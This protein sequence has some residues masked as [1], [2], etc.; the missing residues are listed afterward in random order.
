[1]DLAGDSQPRC[2]H[3]L[4]LNI[5]GGNPGGGGGCPLIS[6]SAICDGENCMPRVERTVVTY[7]S[8]LLSLVKLVVN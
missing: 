5:D 3:S 7:L 4:Y 8:S 6:H 2:R 1:M